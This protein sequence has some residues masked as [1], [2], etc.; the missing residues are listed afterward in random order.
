MVKICL[1][2]QETQ[3]I[4]VRSLGWE[5]PQRRAWQ[6]PPV[7]L[8]GK[9][10]RQ[11]SLV[12]YSPWD[13]K[14]SDMTE[15]L[16]HTHTHTQ[17]HTQGRKQSQNWNNILDHP[18]NESGYESSSETTLSAINKCIPGLIED[19]R[20]KEKTLMCLSRVFF[21]NFSKRKKKNLCSSAQAFLHLSSDPEPAG[22]P[23][24]WKKCKIPLSESFL[25]AWKAVTIHSPS[26][27]GLFLAE[28][29]RNDVILPGQ[30]KPGT[31]LIS[32]SKPITMPLPC[33]QQLCKHVWRG[34]FQDV[35]RI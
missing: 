29:R 31:P 8:P 6:P 7:F 28:A 24:T 14:E 17:T 5:D 26:N 25:L 4:R 30:G 21:F 1:L 20:C 2:M 32:P 10:Y 19:F 12:G 3:D 33:R 13:C 9:P 15:W 35:A 34:H 22:L 27:S 11:R 16:T 23:L 18:A